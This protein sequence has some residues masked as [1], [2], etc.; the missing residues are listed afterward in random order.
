[1]GCME[2]YNQNVTDE[3]LLTL[4]DAEFARRVNEA[5]KRLERPSLLELSRSPLAHTSLV[6]PA[7]V[8]DDLDP[9]PDDRG[10]ALRM[11][12]QWA[13]NRLAPAPPHHPLGTPRPFDDPTWQS[14]RWW[15]YNILRHRY[16]DKLT[17]EQCETLCS[18]QRGIVKAL[19]ALTGIPN[20]SY[21]YTEH[22][23]AVEE[24]ARRLR[25]QLRTHQADD[26]LRSMAVAE[27]YADLQANPPAAALM[28]LAA[29][30]RDAFPR[31][32]LLGMAEAEG[33]QNIIG[34][35]HYLQQQRLLHQGDGGTRLWMSPPLQTFIHAHQSRTRRVR[36]H[37]RALSHYRQRGAPLETAWHLRMAEYHPEAA[38]ILLDAAP[39]LIG[40]LQSPELRDA[41]MAFTPQSLPTSL[42]FQIQR[43][44]CD[45]QRQ[46]GERK[47]ALAACRAALK[48]AGNNLE[49]AQVYRRLGKLYEDH[50]HG[51]ALEYYRR[52][53]ENFGPPDPDL[54]NTLKDRAW[55]YIY[56]QEW[57]QAETDLTRALS[58]AAAEAWRQQADIHTA[59]ASL[60]RQQEKHKTALAHAQRALTLREEHGD[61]QLAAESWSN[62]ALVYA[63]MGEI[64]SALAAYREA[65]TTFE[66]LG[67]QEAIAIVKLNMG[68]ALQLAGRL[69]EAI[70]HYKTCLTTV[71]ELNIPL[72]QSKAC[73]NLVEAYATQKDYKTA[74]QYW[75]QGHQLS[76][77]A[78]LEGEQKWYIALLKEF[79]KLRAV[80]PT[81][82]GVPSTPS[83]ENGPRLSPEEIVALKLAQAEGNVTNRALRKAADI[84]KPTATRKLSNLV[85]LGLLRKQGQGRGVHYILPH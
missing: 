50:S 1:M 58:L 81:W 30:F 72:L 14:P 70:R 84:S 71:A 53:I 60:Y 78:G 61:Y 77:D 56:R 80:E 13:L 10:R 76:R 3:E 83:L 5:L 20:D 16:L 7:L 45:V 59:L 21:Y 23:H 68:T 57:E 27:I 34:T 4:S 8:L 26:E 62:V 49:R 63:N 82:T 40:E 19:L 17:P 39:Q 75:R 18:D 36:R 42:W 38:Q 64:G 41:L 66:K 74:Y 25:E 37:R 67:N 33:H 28:E 54:A 85:E 47:A 44:L 79:P 29:T 11:A 73:S 22:T 35:L 69:D 46:L 32:L 31:T 65:M 24:I 2:T 6:A 15:R 52:A 48:V 55:I 9:T 43:L 51:H 12:L